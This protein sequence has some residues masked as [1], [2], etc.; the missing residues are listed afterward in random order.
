MLNFN[1]HM[2]KAENITTNRGKIE[3]STNAPEFT[4]KT[5]NINQDLSSL[6]AVNGGK[7]KYIVVFIYPADGT[8][9]CSIQVKRFAD[10]K[11][12]FEQMSTLL[13]GV[14]MDDQKSHD[15]FCESKKMDIE[16]VSDQDGNIS[17]AYG[18][19]NKNGW[20]RFTQVSRDTFILKDGK[21]FDIKRSVSVFQDAKETLEKI[22]I[23][24]LKK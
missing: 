22:K 23:D 4:V 14:S 19:L 12:E 13:L 17:E 3:L 24:V 16:L 7:Y 5:K 21:L 6:F 8:P 11:K 9:G 18:S 15:K 2:L 10:L 1:D 20:F